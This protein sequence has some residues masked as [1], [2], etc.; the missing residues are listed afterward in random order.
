MGFMLEAAN[1]GKVGN[2]WKIGV[3]VVCLFVGAQCGAPSSGGRNVLFFLVQEG[4]LS[5]MKCTPYFQ[6]KW[7]GRRTETA[8]ASFQFPLQIVRQSGTW[9]RMFFTLHPEP[10]IGSVCRKQRKKYLFPGC[11]SFSPSS[12]SSPSFCPSS[13]HPLER[14]DVKGTRLSKFVMEAKQA[15]FGVPALEDGS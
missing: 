5:H 7:G 11:L 9:Q 3:V 13:P 14:W 12:P 10:L 6:V 2:E 4:H 1:C 15:S 8:S